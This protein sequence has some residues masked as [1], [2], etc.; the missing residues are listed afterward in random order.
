MATYLYWT[1]GDNTSGTAAGGWAAAKNTFAGAIALATADGDIVKC[2]YTSQEELG[3]DTTYTFG[4]HTTVISVD[5]DSSDTPTAMGTGGWIGNSTTFR[6]VT[7]AGVDK[8]LRFDG[9]TL[10]TA[11]ATADNLSL[12]TSAG[13]QADWS[14]CYFWNGNSNANS[15]I[16]PGSGVAGARFYNCTFRFGATG[17]GFEGSTLCEFVDCTISSAGSAP[18][19]LFP[20][21]I[22][23][24]NMAKVV[25]RGCDLSLVT[26]T[27]VG[28]LDYRLDLTLDRCLLGSGV[29]P[30]AAQSV[31]PNYLVEL[32]IL[33]CASGDTHGLFGYYTAIGSC[34]S[35]VGI[36]ITAGAAA[37]SWKITTTAA[38][39]YSNPFK[40]PLISYYATGTSA[41]SPYMETIQTGASPTAFTDAEIWAE[42]DAK[43]ISTSTKTTNYNDAQAIADWMAGTAGTAQATGTGYAN[44]TGVDSNDSSVKVGVTFTPAEA[45][46]IS[47]RLVVGKASIAGTLYLDPQIRT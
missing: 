4:K 14:N 6:T 29:T 2:H 44:W 21:T 10:R 16:L 25:M 17:Q 24:V 19:T 38:C 11:G 7:I 22:V 9:I 47:G 45:G 30:M 34:V 41:I 23:A 36:Y 12:G 8:R 39:R 33:D 46:Y 31:N 18:T 15:R 37:Q 32:T 35:D 27:L 5:K 43:V 20:V 3:A 13:L 1:G 28:N 26:G 42:F 40:T